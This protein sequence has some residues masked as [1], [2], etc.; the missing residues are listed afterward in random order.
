MS[1]DAAVAPEAT[2]GALLLP[3]RVPLLLPS[4]AWEELVVPVAVTVD[5]VGAVVELPAMDD[6]TGLGMGDELAV[7]VVVTKFKLLRGGVAPVTPLPDI[8]DTEQN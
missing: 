3:V 8:L 6:D 1:C 4:A 5:V 7:A 2:S